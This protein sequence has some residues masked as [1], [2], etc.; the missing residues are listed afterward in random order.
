MSHVQKATSD[1][2]S[3]YTF[4]LSTFPRALGYSLNEIKCIRWQHLRLLSCNVN[5]KFGEN[6]TSFNLFYLFCS[7]YVQHTSVSSQPA[8]KGLVCTHFINYWDLCVCKP[9]PCWSINV[10]SL[11]FCQETKQVKKHLVWQRH[12]RVKKP[13]H[14]VLKALTD[15]S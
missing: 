12:S 1:T 6:V 7:L 13:A 4:K 5:N 3:H 2:V 8:Y 15:F 14:L 9:N 10:T 11:N